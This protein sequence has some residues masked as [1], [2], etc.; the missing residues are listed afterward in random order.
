[1]SIACCSD[2]ASVGYLRVANERLG[3]TWCEA[4][5]VSAAGEIQRGNTV[6]GASTVKNQSVPD[7][8]IGANHLFRPLLARESHLLDVKPVH[9]KLIVQCLRSVCVCVCALAL[10]TPC[11]VLQLDMV[12]VQA[13]LYARW[14]DFQRSAKDGAGCHPSPS[15]VEGSETVTVGPWFTTNAHF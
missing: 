8:F 2:R 5:H 10:P 12:R 9:P 6:T 14:D 1:M 7:G 11:V 3:S 15:H 13:L 4:H